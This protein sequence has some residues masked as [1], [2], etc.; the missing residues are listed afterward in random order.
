[1]SGTSKTQAPLRDDPSLLTTQALWREIEHLKEFLQSQIDET[2]RNQELAHENLVRVPTDVQ[3]AVGNLRDLIERRFQDESAL[4]DEKFA[5][6]QKQFDEKKTAIDAAL[7]AVKEAGNKTESAFIKQI[8]Q[9]VLLFNTST[10]SIEGQIDDVKDRLNRGEGRGE[11]TKETKT[12]QMDSNR[13]WIAVA[14]LALAALAFVI[15][16]GG[17]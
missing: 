4:R 2:K 14:G 6:V 3:K 8:D 16:R 12:S 15:G 9:L 10:K 13:L 11:G 7:A 1:M 5:G 17:L